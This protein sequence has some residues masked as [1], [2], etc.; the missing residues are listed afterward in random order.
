MS[1]RRLYVELWDRFP[2]LAHDNSLRLALPNLDSS[3]ACKLP[4]ACLTMSCH[5]DLCRFTQAPSHS[6]RQ[7]TD[8]CE[9]EAELRFGG[10]RT[11]ERTDFAITERHV[12]RYV[13]GTPRLA[14]GGCISTSAAQVATQQRRSGCHVGIRICPRR[15]PRLVFSLH[16]NLLFA[17]FSLRVPRVFRLLGTPLFALDLN[18]GMLLLP[19]VRHFVISSNQPRR[20]SSQVL[21]QCINCSLVP[22]RTSLSTCHSLFSCTNLFG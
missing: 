7:C 5:H 13:R 11:G 8:F 12:S 19:H 2:S 14:T 16:G 4:H 3:L 9:V 17:A 20:A 10:V 15:S 18:H 6:H 21:S 1:S 22:R